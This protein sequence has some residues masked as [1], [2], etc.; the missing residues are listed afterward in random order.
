MSILGACSVVRSCMLWRGWSSC[1]NCLRASRRKT[2]RFPNLSSNLD[3][4]SSQLSYVDKGALIVDGHGLQHE[5]SSGDAVA[6][7]LIK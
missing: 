7:G 6:V 3:L 2:S 4:N 5:L 1:D